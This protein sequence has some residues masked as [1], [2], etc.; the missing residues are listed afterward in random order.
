MENPIGIF[1]SGVGGLTVVREII[2]QLPNENLIY[3]GDTLRVP[4]GP[5]SLAQVKDFVFEIVEILMERGVKLIVIA[6]NTGTAAGLVEAQ[7][8]YDVPILGVIEPGAKGAVQATRN[9]R[10][11]VVGT[12]GTIKSGA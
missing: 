1:D 6:C 8:R 4:Y 10:I 3:F 5:R 12:V 7:A 11:G 2:G 9:R